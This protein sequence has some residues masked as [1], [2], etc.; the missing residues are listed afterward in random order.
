MK[1]ATKPRLATLLNLALEFV[2]K[3]KSWRMYDMKSSIIVNSMLL[4]DKMISLFSV[5]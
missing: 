3:S 1:E 2:V 5:N 4:V